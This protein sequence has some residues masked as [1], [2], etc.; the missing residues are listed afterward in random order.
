MCFAPQQRALFQHA[1]FQKWAEHVVLLACWLGNVLRATTVCTFW[2]S[3]LLRVLRVWDVFTFFDFQIC[4]FFLLRFFSSLIFSL[5]FF[6][7]LALPTSAFPSVHIVGSL[8]SKFPSNRDFL[9][10]HYQDSHCGIDDHIIPCFEHCTSMINI[11]GM[12]H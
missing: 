8:A 6:S 9:H 1:N 4:F 3:Q 5:L 11:S 2:T 10:H 12:Y 7:S